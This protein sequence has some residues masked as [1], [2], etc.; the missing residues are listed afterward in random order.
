MVLTKDKILKVLKS[1]ELKITPLKK[2][3]I[4]AGSI[5]LSLSNEFRKFLPGKEV[6]DIDENVDYKKYTVKFRANK[7]VI[8][9]NEMLL[10]I[11]KE[12]VKLPE[13]MVGWLQGRTR[14]AR[15]GL[16]VHITAS[17]I[18]PGSENRQVLEMIN[19]GPKP[20]RLKAGARIVQLI[21]QHTEGK[22]KFKGRYNKQV[23]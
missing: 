18:Q 23:L 3:Q 8:Q 21:L 11:T 6:I 2:D 13:N 22:A 14:F 15:M 17:Y 9:P 4:G 7:V 10:G 20:L 19:L 16:N 5:D 12:M 1:K